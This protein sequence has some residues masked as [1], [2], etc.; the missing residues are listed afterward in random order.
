MNETTKAFVL[1]TYKSFIL[2][3]LFHCVI[4]FFSNSLAQMINPEKAYVR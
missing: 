1:L 3:H 4:S 2:W